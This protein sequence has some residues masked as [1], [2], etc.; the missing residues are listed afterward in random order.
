[1]NVVLLVLRTEFA[2]F[3]FDFSG[4]FFS[5]TGVIIAIISLAFAPADCMLA[6]KPGRIRN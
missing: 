6:W 2:W 4:L 3:T 5:R 1:M